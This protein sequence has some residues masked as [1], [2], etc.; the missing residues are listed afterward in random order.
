[1]DY[2]AVRDTGRTE[3]LHTD[4]D[5]TVI[6]DYAH[7]PD[8]LEKVL[9][10]LKPICQKPLDGAVWMSRGEGSIQTGFIWPKQWQSTRIISF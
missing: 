7:T 10:A 6:R 8:G 1:M 5:F 2:P 4:T 3:V 9:P